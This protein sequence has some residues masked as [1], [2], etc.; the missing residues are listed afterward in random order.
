MQSYIEQDTLQLGTAPGTTDSTATA[1]RPHEITPKE[2]LSWLPK[3][4]TPAQQD[5]AIQRH[6]KISEI[7][8]SMQPDTLHM[9][10][11]PKGKS[12]RDASLPQYYRESFFSK[13]S[14]FHPE[15]SGGRLGVAGDPVPYSIAGDNAL[16]ALLLACF[17]L[18]V[19]ALGA[20]RDFIIRQAKSFFYVQRANTT[21][22]TETA[23]ELWIQLL[24]MAQTCLLF[25]VIVFSYTRTYVSDTF[26]ISQHQLIAIYT[27]V[28]A[29]YFLLKTLLYWGVGKVFFDSKK[30][31]QWMKAFLFTVAAEGVLLF[32]VVM[33]IAYFEL[34]IQRA[35]IYVGIVVLFIK[36]LAFFKTILIFFRKNGVFLQIIL[37][38]CALEI[39]PLAILLGSL[40]LI[41]NFL[42]VNF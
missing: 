19:F 17:V 6:V 8:W 22:I 16:T 25:S 2:V 40:G 41:N 24:L 20:A 34:S 35:A 31:E 23:G 4:A 30:I 14:L 1:A 29:A 36:I 27:G 32:P 12:F 28:T 3:T 33:L 38:L 15:L 39:V 26:V 18:A 5:S 7:H 37:Y 10:G 13:D 21:E 11:Q 42:K 9:P